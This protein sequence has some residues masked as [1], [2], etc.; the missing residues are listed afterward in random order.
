MR[1]QTIRIKDENSSLI[2]KLTGYESRIADLTNYVNTLR[3]NFQDEED[4]IQELNV[5]AIVC[6]RQNESKLQTQ[7]T[8]MKRSP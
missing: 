6:Q 3:Q 4:V 8:L 2:D 7:R 5:D 1:E